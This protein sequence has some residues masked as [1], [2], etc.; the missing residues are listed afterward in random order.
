M[1]GGS[2]YIESV[3]SRSKYEYRVFYPEDMFGELIYGH[4]GYD[5]LTLEN[6]LAESVDVVALLVHSYGTIAEL[7]AFCNYPSLRD[8]LIVVNDE[9][10]K[11]EKSFINLGPIRYLKKSST[12][13]ILYLPMNMDSVDLLANSLIRSSKGIFKKSPQNC[14]LTNP[15]ASYYF[16]LSL[17]YVF[18]SI[19][20]PPPIGWTE[21]GGL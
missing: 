1:G 8:K 11:R 10:Y 13:T 6:M 3:S 9:Q 20:E 12:S 16:Y 18:D 5:L 15:I 4:K 19:S 7:G 21:N 14:E 2:K 17:V